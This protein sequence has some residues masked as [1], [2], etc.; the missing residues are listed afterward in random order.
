[1]LII[2]AYGKYSQSLFWALPTDQ[3]VQQAG[4]T[5]NNPGILYPPTNTRS[6]EQYWYDLGPIMPWP[7]VELSWSWRVREKGFQLS[8]LCLPLVFHQCNVISLIAVDN[9]YS[10]LLV[11]QFVS[12]LQNK[13]KGSTSHKTD[14]VKFWS[15]PLIK[16]L[17]RPIQYV[18]YVNLLYDCNSALTDH[19]L[20][21][22]F[23]LIYWNL[24][25]EI[26]HL[27]LNKVDSL[28]RIN[29]WE[30]KGGD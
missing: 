27:F 15:K 22:W 9:F 7:L 6:T 25:T 20:P 23:F 18:Q 13:A 12:G 3:A 5:V 2:H 21:W 29:N 4:L 28:Y 24:A 26:G 16:T 30:I 1:M 10:H 11:E 8:L 19:F 14:G 17:F